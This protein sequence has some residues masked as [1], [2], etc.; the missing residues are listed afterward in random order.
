M[1]RCVPI[2][3]MLAASAA[4]AEP[5]PGA[6]LDLATRQAACIELC[7]P[8][9]PCGRIDY[10]RRMCEVVVDPFRADAAIEILVC[11]AENEC[12]F[13]GVAECEQDVIDEIE[14]TPMYYEMFSRCVAAE[15]SCGISFGCY[16]PRHRIRGDAVLREMAMCFEPP[17]DLG[18]QTCFGEAQSPW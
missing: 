12:G 16:E 14:P 3:A 10:C 1:T 9:T 15:A 5:G 6:R 4:C 8:D 13:P 7:A 11:Y 2:I 17:C 18:I